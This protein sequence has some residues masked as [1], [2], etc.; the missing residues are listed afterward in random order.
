MRE[1]KG[2]TS[3]LILPSSPV[4]DYLGGVQGWAGIRGELPRGDPT[5]A[6]PGPWEPVC[7][8]IFNSCP[9]LCGICSFFFLFS[10]FIYF[11]FMNMNVLPACTMCST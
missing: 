5:A 7:D 10:R 4:R 8:F 6:A 1:S 3:L 11:Y 2:E 9:S